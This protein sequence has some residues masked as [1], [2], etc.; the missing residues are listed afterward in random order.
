M[1]RGYII[2]SELLSDGSGVAVVAVVAI[3][4][5]VAVVAV[6]VVVVP[7]T[8]TATTATTL[9]SESSP[10]P[11]DINLCHSTYPTA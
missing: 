2:G 11:T 3:V 10:P 8:I 6:A 7:E 4:A 1:A 5:V 9:P